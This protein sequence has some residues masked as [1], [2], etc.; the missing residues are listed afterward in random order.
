MRRKKP[1]ALIITAR[2]TTSS[3]G[4][5]TTTAKGSGTK[6]KQKNRLLEAG[7]G[8]KV[9]C[10]VPSETVGPG[11]CRS[12]RNNVASWLTVSD[13]GQSG[14]RSSW[15]IAVIIVDTVMSVDVRFGRRPVICDLW[16][17]K[18]VTALNGKHS[19]HLRRIWRRWRRRLW[20]SGEPFLTLQEG[21]HQGTGRQCTGQEGRTSVRA[22]K[23]YEQISF[24]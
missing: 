2:I 14:A 24:R 22:A 21:H 16:C 19:R 8:W 7:Q 20:R 1:S 9:M 5:V 11:K 3:R 4:D 6:L 17:V 18:S 15:F 13:S 12:G 23:Y 10:S